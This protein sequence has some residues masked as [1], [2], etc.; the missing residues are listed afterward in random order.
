[1]IVLINSAIKIAGNIFFSQMCAFRLLYAWRDN[2][3][4]EEDESTGW[5]SK[6]FHEFSRLS[7]DFPAF[8]F[9]ACKQ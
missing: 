9:A 4:R 1:M 6:Y 7:S 3:A 2:I 5:D 8:H